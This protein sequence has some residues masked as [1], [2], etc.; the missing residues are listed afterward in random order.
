MVSEVVV[1]GAGAVGGNVALRLAQ[2][3]ASVTLLDAGEPGYGT[4]GSS[5]AWANANDKP[6]RHYHD[7]NAAG[8]REHATLQAEL[9]GDWYHPGG[10]LEWE[11]TDAARAELRAK[12]EQL[13][14][15]GYAARW[16]DQAELRELEPDL[17]FDPDEAREVAYFAEEGWVN[18]RAFA[19]GLSEA[20]ARAGGTV[21]TG[22]RVAEIESAGGKVA[23]VRTEDGQR[24]P[25]DVVVNCAGPR[26][27][28]VARL[29]GGELPLANTLGLL[30]FTT[31]GEPLARRVIHAPGCNIRPYDG[32]ALILHH[33]RCDQTLRPETVADASLEACGM[34]L[35]A[36]RDLFPGLE[37]RT[38]AEARIGTRPMPKDGLSVVGPGIGAD[39]HYLVVTHSG[40]TLGPI[41]GKLVA[42]E[43]L[44]GRP[45]PTLAPFRPDRFQ[46]AAVPMPA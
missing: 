12:V 20:V 33:D 2:G 21:L 19:R 43:L 36:A 18:G 29:A 9:G 34:I 3:G 35:R 11:A 10:N 31:G 27:D 24:F 45:D 41:L 14:A 37:G 39:G 8:M 7:L 5:F 23:G 4:S 44:T 26:A 40:I 15:W 42:G 13:L 38:V 46:K 16:I 25:A 1:I 28:Q 22:R 32:G 17:R 6:P 30:T